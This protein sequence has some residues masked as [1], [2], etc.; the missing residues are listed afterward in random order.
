MFYVQESIDKI[1]R[2]VMW[3][4]PEQ[5]LFEDIHADHVEG[6]NQ[7]VLTNLIRFYLIKPTLKSENVDNQDFLGESKYI[8]NLKNQYN[9]NYGF[10]MHRHISSKRPR[11]VIFFKELHII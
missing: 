6:F 1:P 11:F 4:L 10:K 5:P 2:N 7:E 8:H 9:R 3:N